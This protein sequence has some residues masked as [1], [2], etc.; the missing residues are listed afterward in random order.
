MMP[1]TTARP[2]RH[3][4]TRALQS[5]VIDCP[6]IGQP[7]PPDHYYLPSAPGG[8]SRNAMAKFQ[9]SHAAPDC[10]GAVTSPS[11]SPWRSAHPTAADLADPR[12]WV[13]EATAGPGT[14]DPFHCDWK[15]WRSS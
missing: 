3:V 7:Q 14:E 13:W 15:H 11:I 10:A 6:S 8:S 12:L 5:V 9:A 4:L 1:F 2:S